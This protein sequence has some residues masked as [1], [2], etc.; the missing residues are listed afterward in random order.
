MS[1]R[2]LKKLRLW[3][4]AILLIVLATPCLRGDASAGDDGWRRTARGWEVLHTKPVLV[5]TIPTHAETSMHPLILAALQ[6]AVVAAAYW[7]FP[8]KK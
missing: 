4:A 8:V 6:I 3:G 7:R 2:F 1:P 5:A